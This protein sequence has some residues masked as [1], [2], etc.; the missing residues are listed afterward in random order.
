MASERS[1]EDVSAAQAIIRAYLAGELIDGQPVTESELKNAQRVINQH[2]S[3][4]GRAATSGA[5][6]LAEVRRKLWAG[7]DV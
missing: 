3:S 2:L 5:R 4:R 1:G 7:E 6:Q